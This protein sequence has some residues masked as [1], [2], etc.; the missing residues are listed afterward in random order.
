MLQVRKSSVEIGIRRP[1]LSPAG[2]NGTIQDEDKATGLNSVWSVLKSLSLGPSYLAA[3]ST[4][5]S[6]HLDPPSSGLGL[7][8]A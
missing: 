8:P 7:S 1:T 5:A 2:V 6:N 4:L 3:T